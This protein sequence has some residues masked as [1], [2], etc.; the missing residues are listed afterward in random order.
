MAHE[1]ASA[2]HDCENSRGT[3]LKAGVAR[4]P[5]AADVTAVLSMADIKAF[6]TSISAKSGSPV[7]NDRPIIVLEALPPDCP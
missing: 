3:K 1:H 6:R 7:F 5:N 2:S 4:F